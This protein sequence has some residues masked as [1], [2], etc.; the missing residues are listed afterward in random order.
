MPITPITPITRTGA[1]ATILAL[2][3]AATPAFAADPAP[4]V[5]RVAATANDTYAQAYYAQD[6]GYFKKA[7]L[8]VQLTTFTNGASVA[9]AVA[10]GAV[11]IGI[12]NV[13]QIATAVSKGIPFQYFAGGGL[14]SSEAPTSALLVG[15]AS[16]V[17]LAKDFDGKTI[18]VSTLKDLSYLATR[19]WLADN[20]ADLTKITFIEVP[21]SAMGASLQRGTVAGAV[22]SEPFFTFAKE[23]GAHVFAPTYD[24]IAKHF[25]ISGWFATADYLKNNAEAAKR[26]TLAIHE[27]GR[28]ANTHHAESAAILVKYAKLTPEVAARMTRCQ[29]AERLSVAQLQPTIDLSVRYKLLDRPLAAADIIAASSRASSTP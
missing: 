5:V 4:L 25:L 26:F 17:K 6:L 3:I 13:V 16:T 8:D 29:Y 1:L 2:G 27:A 22:I 14:Y 12:S 20:G 18:A 7:G 15:S 10:S 19:S 11:D 24:A 21:F 28:W 23:A 9:Q